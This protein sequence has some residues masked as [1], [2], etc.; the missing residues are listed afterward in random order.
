MVGVHFAQGKMIN[1]IDVAKGYGFK[2][3]TSRWHTKDLEKVT[4]TV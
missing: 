1:I 2:G 4:C 3:M